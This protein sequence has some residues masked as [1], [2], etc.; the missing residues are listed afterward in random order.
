MLI[1]KLFKKGNQEFDF[2]VHACDFEVDE[3]AHFFEPWSYLF[4]QNHNFF[5]LL[6]RITT[7]LSK[8]QISKMMEHLNKEASIRLM[9]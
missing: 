1:C 9:A 4:Y 3:I 6:S 8:F 2:Y 7:L 5:T